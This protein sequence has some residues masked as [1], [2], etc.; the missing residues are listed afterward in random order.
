MKISSSISESISRCALTIVYVGVICS[1]VQ[2]CILAQGG[3]R[4]AH[5][6]DEHSKESVQQIA[7][8]PDGRSVAFVR[9]RGLGSQPGAQGNFAAG[10]DP[11]G[12]RSG[13]D[14]WVQEGPGALAVNVTN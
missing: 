6:S 10:P 5:V 1:T 4:L 12:A 3:E 8:S 2:H 9:T 7:F 11:Y 13:A 14:I